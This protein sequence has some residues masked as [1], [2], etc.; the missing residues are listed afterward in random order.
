MFKVDLG[1]KPKKFFKQLDQKTQDK[2]RELFSVL[3]LNP[4]PA[5]DF[6]LTKLAGL[7]DCYRIRVG[8]HRICYNVNTETQLVTVYRI[9]RRSETTYR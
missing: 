7:N 5:K 4:W 8:K 1:N 3:E 2:F 6:D 9:E